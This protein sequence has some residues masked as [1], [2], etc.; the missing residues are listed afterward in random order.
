[1]PETCREDMLHEK[2]RQ[3][4]LERKYTEA[5]TEEQGY[6][7]RKGEARD[8]ILCDIH[9]WMEEAHQAWARQR[10]AMEG[11]VDWP[12]CVGSVPEGGDC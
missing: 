1:M 5:A 2:Y 9:R 6:W 11:A 10:K 4:L 12:W 8:I 7:Q 3:I